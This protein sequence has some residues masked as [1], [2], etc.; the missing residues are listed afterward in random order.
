MM[1]CMLNKVP[2]P[3]YE[4]FEDR[5]NIP[6][7]YYLF[8]ER[9]LR[10]GRHNKELWNAA[11]TRKNGRNN[12]PFSSSIFEAH[13]LTTIRENYFTWMYQ[14]LANPNVMPF[15]KDANDFKVE[16]DFDVLPED[17][18]CTCALISDL[19]LSS[20]YRYNVQTKSFESIDVKDIDLTETYQGVIK[21]IRVNTGEERT[22]EDEEV[23]QEQHVMK[24][25]QSTEK[26]MRNRIFVD[27][28][29]RLQELV[30][31]EKEQRQKTLQQLREKVDSVRPTFA[32]Y[33][34][35]KKSEFNVNAK[36]SFRMYV[37]NSGMDEGGDNSSVQPA[38]K[39]AKKPSPNKCRISVEKLDVLKQV[40]NKILREKASGLRKAWE[41]FYKKTVNL[42]LQKEAEKHEGIH[43]ATDFLEELED[44]E[45]NWKK[46][47]CATP[48]TANTSDSDEGS[49]NSSL[50]DE[51]EVTQQAEI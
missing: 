40:N 24:E 28:R 29:K 41:R 11:I 51:I 38:A 36:R 33:S 6:K 49:L 8:F 12:I 44:L 30:D 7:R 3:A 34:R 14:A 19:P 10:P 18:A 25:V 39:K 47:V 31:S 22:E 9:I 45:V 15:L 32:T 4:T 16:Y 46:N 43:K 1:E 48:D 21:L 2:F 35:E 42:R 37:E 27:Q 23:N 13:V 20:E 5:E 50:N 17:L 26:V